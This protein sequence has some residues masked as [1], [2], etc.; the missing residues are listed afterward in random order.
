LKE[1]KH[2]HGLLGFDKVV[3]HALVEW[4][5][6]I[7]RNQLY[8][9]VG[10]VGPM[11]S[12]VQIALG[13]RDLFWLPVDQYRRDGHIVKGLQR[14]AQS[15]GLS[16]ATATL[17]LGQKFFGTIQFMAEFAFDVVNPDYHRQRSQA[18]ILQSLAQPADFRE[19]VTLAMNAFRRGFA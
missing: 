9:I 17:E 4:L 8:S 1:L 7:R 13:I 19:G 14:G 6:D 2:R 5:R 11:H 15:F 16:T 3:N 10:G 12:L 18:D